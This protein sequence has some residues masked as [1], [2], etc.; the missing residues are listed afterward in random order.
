MSHY[1]DLEKYGPKFFQS[2]GLKIYGSEFD[3]SAIRSLNSAEGDKC[4]GYRSDWEAAGIPFWHGVAIY[5]L[6]KMKPYSDECRDVRDLG[7]VPPG[8]WVKK[9]YE[10][11]KEHF[12][13]S[14]SV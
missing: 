6:T 7:W 10:R 9:N 3:L 13:E 8:E 4:Y 2:L 14:P 12:G 1:Q 11:F 5:Y